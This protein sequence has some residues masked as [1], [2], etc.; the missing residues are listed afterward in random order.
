MSGVAYP[1]TY[2]AVMIS[3][4]IV[5]GGIAAF[6][7][8]PLAVFARKGSRLH[9]K[10][11]QIYMMSVVLICVS[12]MLA[13]LDPAFLAE[14]W[15]Q[16][17]VAK[18]FG[19]IFQASGN[20]TMFFLFLVVM[21]AYMSF[22]AV[23]IWPRIGYGKAERIHS[24]AFDWVLTAVMAVYAAGFLVIGIEDLLSHNKY[25]T[26]FLGGA[27]LMLGFV[28]FDIYT[29]V[30]KPQVRRYPWWMLHMTKLCYAWAGL[31]DAFWIRLRVYI[32]PEDLVQEPLPVGTIIWLGLTIA[33]FILHRRSM[34]E[35]PEHR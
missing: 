8:C 14:Y 22:S 27:L 35:T 34:T 13:L 4:H 23:R 11:G 21:L 10:A 6:I 18:G 26:T 28:G 15:K 32:L 17:S 19:E 29:F 9:R 2:L 20:P 31:L 12:G 24:N 25:A 1:D 5:F 30:A 3:A 33:G 7:L 16:E